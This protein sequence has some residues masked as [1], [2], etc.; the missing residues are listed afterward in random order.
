MSHS[1]GPP[2]QEPAVHGAPAQEPPA[3]EPPAQE[4][5]AQASAAQEP[6][7]QRLTLQNSQVTG[8]KRR[9]SSGSL[10]ASELKQLFRRRRTQAM[11]LALA[12]IPV[13]IA[14]VVRV[15]S[16]VPPG[17]GPAFLDRIS[18]NGLFVAVTAMLVSVPLFLPLTIGV[19]AGD[20]IAGEAGLGTLRY[21]LVAPAGRV[22]LL[23]VKYAGAAVF[24]LSAP[25]AVALA[26]AGIGWALFPVGPVAL[27]SGDL[28]EPDEALV[29][30]LLIA[31][32]QAVSL[33]GLSAIGLFL[34]TLTDVPVGAMAATIV[35]SVV[36]QVLDQLPQLEWLHPWLFTHYWFGFA[37]LLRQPIGWDSF[38]DNALLQAGYI[39]VFGALA[40][41]RFVSKDVLS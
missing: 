12:A 33:L 14:V 13:V 2:M 18:Q 8:T 4:P 31:A 28:V 39:A 29:R 32:Y 26:G 16:A 38:G 6:T 21:L 23:L 5:A 34:S 27:L 35:L 15:S 30:M 36:S 11:L 9:P 17:R 24:C 41:G 25:L 22:R 1:D 3:Q 10:L 7:A 19:V 37:D 40:Y 20:T